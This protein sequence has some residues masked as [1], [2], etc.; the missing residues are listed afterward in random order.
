ML[1]ATALGYQLGLGSRRPLVLF[2]FL[3]G[4]VTGSMVAIIDFNRRVSDTQID[5]APL[6]WTIQGF[7]PGLR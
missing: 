4:M 1:G 7:G 2:P 3:V 5:P 6:I